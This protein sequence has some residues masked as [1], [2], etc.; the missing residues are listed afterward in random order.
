MNI[1]DIIKDIENCSSMESNHKEGEDRECKA[2]LIK[3][4]KELAEMLNNIE[5]A[6]NL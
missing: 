6:S 1:Q 5:K 4:V 3:N 2:C